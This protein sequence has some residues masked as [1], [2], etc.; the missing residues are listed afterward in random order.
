MT[1][2][3]KMMMSGISAIQEACKVLEISYKEPTGLGCVLDLG[4]GF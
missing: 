3:G 4:I 2:I 1:F